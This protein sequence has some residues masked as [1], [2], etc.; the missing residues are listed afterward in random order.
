MFSLNLGG[1]VNCTQ[2]HNNRQF[3]VN[4]PLW[5]STLTL[6]QF[7]SKHSQKTHAQGYMLPL[8]HCFPTP[9]CFILLPE[10]SMPSPEDSMLT[11]QDFILTLHES[12][13]TPTR[14]HSNSPRSHANS[15]RICTDT[16][17]SATI[18]P[19][20]LMLTFYGSKHS[21]L[22]SVLFFT[23]CCQLVLT[24]SLWGRPGHCI[25]GPSHYS[26]SSCEVC[27]TH[28]RVWG[29]SKNN[30]AINLFSF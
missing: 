19:Q 22:I 26:N 12:I 16:R 25:K 6:A 29:L 5:S 17:F 24:I 2:F 7:S 13:Q 1:N 27:Y 14:I 9:H 15:K 28:W 3:K 30:D 11:P 21:F 10:D 4:I 8:Q 23:R 18:T 20:D